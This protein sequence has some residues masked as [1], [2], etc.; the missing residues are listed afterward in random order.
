MIQHYGFELGKA[1]LQVSYLHNNKHK[2]HNST[3][4]YLGSLYFIV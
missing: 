1:I 3:A 2:K 4:T